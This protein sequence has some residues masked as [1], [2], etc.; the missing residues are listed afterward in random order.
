MGVDLPDN[1]AQK[2]LH[3]PLIKR[4]QVLEFE[5]EVDAPDISEVVGWDH[6]NHGLVDN[7]DC[8]SIAH[9]MFINAKL[10]VLCSGI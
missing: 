8:F 10:V 7:F 1:L 2:S 9:D 4:L 6:G 5:V 3:I